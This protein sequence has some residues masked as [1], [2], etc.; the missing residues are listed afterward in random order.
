MPPVIVKDGLKKIVIKQAKTV[1]QIGCLT[2]CC[3]AVRASTR[4]S[5]MDVGEFVRRMK[6]FDGYDGA[7]NLKWDIA[8]M[9]CGFDNYERDVTL[10]TAKARIDNNFPVFLRVIGKSGHE[11]FVLGIGY[12]ATGWRV[13]DVG[14]RFGS[15]YTDPA[16]NTF[17]YDRV[18]R[19]DLFA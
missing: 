11:H 10:D 3:E 8:A 14:T 5:L 2:C 9:I 7:G 17:P 15:G 1:K 13:H 12:D 4:G 18:T 19:I 6:E 16:R